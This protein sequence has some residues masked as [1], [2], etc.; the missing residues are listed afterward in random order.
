MPSIF[1]TNDLDYE[2][3]PHLIIIGKWTNNANYM[4]VIHRGCQK[5]AVGGKGT[6][7]SSYIVLRAFEP[8][9]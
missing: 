7:S 3:H 1:L 9:V 8:V 4:C 5:A 6:N 2:V